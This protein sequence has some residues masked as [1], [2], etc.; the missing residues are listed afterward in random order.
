MSAAARGG[1]PRRRLARRR[2]SDRPRQSWRDPHAALCR[3]GAIGRYRPRP[4]DRA[5][6]RYAR[7]RRCRRPIR[8]RPD[9]RAAGRRPRGREGEGDGPRG[10]LVAQRRPCRPRRRM[11]GARGGRGPD[12]D[13]FRQRPRLAARRPVRRLRAPAFDRAVLHRRSARRRAAGRARLRDLSRR[14]RQ[15]Q[16]REP[17]RQAAAAGCADRPR[18]RA[19]RRPRAALRP[20]DA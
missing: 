12:L 13:P 5:S 7:H 17:G 9:G 6:R 16:C 18:R 19:L 20:A 15:G 1:A 8:L 2:Q 3:L 4:D 14:G 11:G 10:D